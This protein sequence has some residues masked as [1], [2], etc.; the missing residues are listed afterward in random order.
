MAP[1]LRKKGQVSKN[2]K[3]VKREGRKALKS[4]KKGKTGGA[5][6]TSS[7]ADQKSTKSAKTF[8]SPAGKGWSPYPGGPWRVK[9]GTT[10]KGREAV[11]E[12][13]IQNLQRN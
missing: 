6:G 9:H 8:T 7:R 10:Q 2:E 11:G 5:F 3:A 13:D 1:G 4:L 12:G